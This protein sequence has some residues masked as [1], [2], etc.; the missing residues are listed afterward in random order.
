MRRLGVCRALTVVSL[1]LPALGL[2]SVPAR[3]A[4]P[5]AAPQ[6][7]PQAVVPA[8]LPKAPAADTGLEIS[9]SSVSPAIAG[10]GQSVTVAGTVTNRGSSAV[11]RPVARVVLGSQPLAVR[12]DVDRWAAASGPAQGR[13]V[14]RSSLGASIAPG[15]TVPF[16]VQVDGAAGLREPTYGAL[17]LSV[18]VSDTSLRTFAGYQRLKQYQPMRLGW[19]V[20]LTLDPDPALF[21]AEGDARQAAW[22]RALGAGSRVSRVL[23]S[24]ESTGSAPVTWAIDPSLLPS[25][26]P[27]ET[28]EPVSS[29][30]KASKTSEAALRSAVEERI[31]ASAPR[32]SPWVLPDTDAD[33]AAVAD[34]GTSSDL[35][36]ELVSRAATVARAVDGRADV[37]WPADGQHTPARESALRR[38]YSQ[39]RLGAQLAAQSSLPLDGNTQDA[40]RRSAD[41]LPVLAYD[42]SLSALLAQVET[43]ESAALGVQR[44]IA[45]TAA[46]LDERPGTSSRSVL[47]AAPRSFSPD[48]TAAATFFETAAS[49]PWLEPVTTDTLLT[50]A[51]K[52]VPMPKEV[53]TRPTPTP[54]PSTPSPGAAPPSTPP[55]DPYSES[56][57]LLTQRR[58]ESLEQSLDTVRGVALIR[59]DGDAF[60]RT[61][62]RAA[63]Q[64]ASSRWRAGPA[65]WT[66]LN[67]GIQAATRETTSSIRV[68]RSNINFLAETGRLQI[69]VTN[70][71]DVA[72]E[73]VK[74]TLEPATPRLRIDS[75]PPV[76]RIGPNSRATAIVGVTTL[77]AGSVPLRTTLTTPDGTVIGQGADVVVQVT[78]T[79]DWVY[80]TL[81]GFAGIILVLGIWRSVRRKPEPVNAAEPVPSPQGTA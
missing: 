40:H 56:R 79:G 14:G 11:P 54:S 62:G 10:P 58:V 36:P 1:L 21:G 67:A 32:H 77:A 73:N 46:L 37:A 80:W 33:V 29:D 61:W 81:G 59:D 71:L 57:P 41:G 72:V 45:D 34:A 18:E 65:G 53:G 76:M 55:A 3:A 31:R 51:R 63:E 8:V 44:F 17:P 12:E 26:L 35:V 25:L 47:V 22:D 70:D 68:S 24:T 38:L 42:D 75:Q 74:L 78:P 69:T 4:T 16:R 43:P 39:P 5:S 27:E 30:A 28:G 7:G 48:P 13:E 66:R 15:A 49:I 23:E 6:G 60:A 50:D 52:A 20:P 9:L 64:L 2:A 19:V